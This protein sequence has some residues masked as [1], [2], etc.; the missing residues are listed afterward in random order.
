MDH[1]ADRRRLI[2]PL[3]RFSTGVF[4]KTKLPASHK[5]VHA[6]VTDP[7]QWLPNFC[8]LPVLVA[9][10]AVTEL[11]VLLIVLA[12][13]DE[14]RAVLP[15]LGTTSVF[16]QWLAL[17]CVVALCKLKPL[18]ARFAPM[19]GVLIAYGLIIVIV[20]LA[21]ELVFLID[22]T[23]LLRLTLP[24]EFHLRFVVGSTALAA[25]IAAAMLR[26]FFVLEQWR[27]RVRA[28]ARSQFDALQARI[29]PH[30]LFNSMN[31]IASLIRSDPVQAERSVEDLAD[32]FRAALRSGER[33]GTLG[34]EFD[35]I[36]RYLAIEQLRLGAR[37]QVDL[38]LDELP[39]DLP[40]PPLLMQP[41]VENAIYHG[42]E[43]LP[44]G[45]VLKIVGQRQAGMIEISIIN[46]CPAEAP[47]ARTHNGMALNNIRSRIEYHFGRRGTLETI[48]G[49]EQFICSLRLPDEN[50]DR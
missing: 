41:L 15:R 10:A 25:L 26:Y 27:E 17:L 42:I 36:Q 23:L 35:L 2:A 37:L 40:L 22:Q 24:A 48:R 31:T 19:H 9:V 29:R 34:D 6:A 39:L 38:Q 8:S 50:T 11:A 45:G 46:P 7:P 16:A 43:R 44:Q 33:L 12:P 4:L 49:T 21:S 30:F 1:G 20:A 5:S 18:L 47:S 13:S 28:V 3:G 14:P 32:L